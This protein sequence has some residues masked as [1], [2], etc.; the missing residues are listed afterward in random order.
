MHRTLA[1][2]SKKHG[3]ILFLEFG[4]RPVLVVSSPSAVEECFTKNDIIFANRPRILAG[5]HLGYDYSTL[6]WAPYGDHW[7]NLRRMAS[8]EILSSNRIQKYA[9]IRMDEVRSLIL[10]LYKITSKNG[11][12]QFHVVEMKSLFFEL[13]LNVIMRM[14]AGKRYYGEKEG[15]LEEERKFKEVVTETLELSGVRNNVDYIPALKW[16]GVNKVE[17]KQAI[18]QRRRDELIQNLIEERKKSISNSSSEERN[19]TIID[20]LL[21]LQENN[22]EY[23]TNVMI[24]GMV[25]VLIT[26]GT[27]TSAATMEWALTLLLN[28]PKTLVKAQEEIDMVVGTN[29]LMDE[30][31][32]DKLPYLGGIINETF[33]MCPITPLLIPHES[34]EECTVGGFRI[35]RG[36][37]LLVNIWAM[38]NDPALW[39]DPTIF[40]PE[41]FVGPKTENNN[42]LIL[43]FGAG[44]RKCPGERM[45]MRSIPLVL[46]CLIQCFEW[47]RIGEE[48]VDMSE[49]KG[50]TMPK[51]K[52]LVAKCRPR[53]AMMNL[54]SQI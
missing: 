23:Y 24:R 49:G 51:A 6:V 13:I 3:P 2:L 54:L 36:T 42:G 19:R 31:D 14:I 28:N 11:D 45:A 44:R 39:E 35:P 25:Q 37:M 18:L 20:V 21:A 46:G 41:R 29:R 1:R 34:S 53:S 30:T 26:A 5:K 4:S 12:D 33:R 27:E 50:L 48:M 32:I 40:K 47:E 8:L 52:P 43:P 15:E 17:K 10:R 38:H 22:P 7:R 9:G 16:V